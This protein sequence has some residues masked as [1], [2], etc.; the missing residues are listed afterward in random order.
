[1][2]IG[3]CLNNQAICKNIRGR[4]LT[5]TPTHTFIPTIFIP[6]PTT[7]PI[8]TPTVKLCTMSRGSEDR[9]YSEHDLYLLAKL[10]YAEAPDDP[11][12]GQLAVANVVLNRV[13][14]NWASTI[15]KVIYQKINGCGQFSPIWDGSRL[16]KGKPSDQA[17]RNAK[18]AL[19]GE[20]NIPD[21]IFYF[22]D[23][24]YTSKGNWIHTRK[25]Y[26]KIGCHIFCY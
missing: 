17:I 26:M 14:N 18:R 23:P 9:A 19:M 5:P 21:T 24:R 22:Y 10:I 3:T 6:T 12:D 7:S 8:V 15:E 13:N 16:F 4:L 1:M 25:Q 20:K 2:Y 11:D